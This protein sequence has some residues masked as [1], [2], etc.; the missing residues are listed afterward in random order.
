MC[1]ITAATNNFTSARSVPLTFHFSYKILYH[2]PN[3]ASPEPRRSVGRC[4]IPTWFA[5]AGP[6][7]CYCFL[8]V[9]DVP[10]FVQLQ[11]LPYHAKSIVL[12]QRWPNHIGTSPIGRR[13]A[14]GLPLEFSAPPRKYRQT[15]NWRLPRKSS[16]ERTLFSTTLCENCTTICPIHGSADRLHPPP[17]CKLWLL[18]PS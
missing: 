13:G 14:E 2:L 4:L 17:T 9:F 18:L 3:V 1:K 11:Y 10:P 8:L 15:E 5:I 12:P 7:L 6:V 16:P